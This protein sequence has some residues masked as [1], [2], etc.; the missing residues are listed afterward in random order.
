MKTKQNIP[1]LRVH[2]ENIARRKT[3]LSAS[4]KNLRRAYITSLTAHLKTL[5][6]TEANIPKR[7]ECSG[8]NN[9]TQG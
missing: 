5:E 1:K 6:Q 8:G 2:N 3:Q 7:S 9:Q 4:K